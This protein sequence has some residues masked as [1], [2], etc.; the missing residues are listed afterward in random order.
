M[1]DNQSSYFIDSNLEFNSA[2]LLK[3]SQLRSQYQFSF[4]DSLI[5]ASSISAGTS[6]LISEDMQHGMIVEKLLEIINPFQDQGN[7]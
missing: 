3:A 1:S 2:I 7:L 4:W 5:V 6:F